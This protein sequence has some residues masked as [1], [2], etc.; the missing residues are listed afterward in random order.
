MG[1]ADVNV[2]RN[3]CVF[4]DVGNVTTNHLGQG[5]SNFFFSWRTTNE[6]GVSSGCGSVLVCDTVSMLSGDVMTCAVVV[7]DTYGTHVPKHVATELTM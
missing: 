7:C 2:A 6:I 5:F 4:L 3:E 1:C